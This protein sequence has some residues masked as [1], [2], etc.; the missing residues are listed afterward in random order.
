[1]LRIIFV[2]VIVI[3]AIVVG[4][5][6]NLTLKKYIITPLLILT[7]QA[8]AVANGDLTAS[9]S[10]R[11]SGEVGILVD[12]FTKLVFNLRQMVSN[13]AQ[14]GSDLVSTSQLLSKSGNETHSVSKEISQAIE[15]VAEGASKQ[16]QKLDQM[17]MVI[18]QFSSSVG[19]IAIGA[20]EQSINVTQTSTN[21]NQ[22]ANSIQEVAESAQTVFQV[23]EKTSKWPVMVA[24]P[25]LMLLREW[26]RLRA[27]FFK[28]KVLQ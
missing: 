3:L 7:K 27:R 18:K 17:S 28:P 6:V 10:V 19:Q 8:E 25:L 4:F 26:K 1:M 12:I 23:A 13:I 11:A 16:T 9:V 21:I 22:M 15:E 14:A 20:Q 24:R 2:T 5:W